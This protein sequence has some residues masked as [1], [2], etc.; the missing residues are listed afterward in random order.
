[1]WLMERFCGRS[2]KTLF[3]SMIAG[4]LIC[5][6]FGTAWFALF[7]ANGGLGA[8]LGACVIPFILPDCVK[9]ALSV[10]LVRRIRKS[11]VLD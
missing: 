11:G 8:I 9:I 10:L 2:R 5:Y 4:L 6:A 7:F 1:M 3:L